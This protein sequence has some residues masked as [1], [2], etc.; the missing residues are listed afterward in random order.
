MC[1][2]QCTEYKVLNE[3]MSNTNIAKVSDNMQSKL[4]ILKERDIIV[5]GISYIQSIV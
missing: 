5:Q 3:I 4:S 1:L 2:G